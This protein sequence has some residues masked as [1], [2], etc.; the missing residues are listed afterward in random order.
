VPVRISLRGLG[1]QVTYV[2]A[3]A[4]HSQTEKKL[5][6]KKGREAYRRCVASLGEAPTSQQDRKAVQPLRVKLWIFLY[7]SAY[8]QPG[9][10]TVLWQFLDASEVV[11]AR[12]TDLGKKSADNPM[13]LHTQTWQHPSEMA[14]ARRKQS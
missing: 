3:A 1:P 2:A 13:V 12:V 5:M 14:L 7:P 9:W 8:T 6:E 10:R 4:G 11:V